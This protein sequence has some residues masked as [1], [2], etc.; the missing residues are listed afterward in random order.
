MDAL[1]ARTLA[2]VAVEDDDA[3]RTLLMEQSNQRAR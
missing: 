2:A 3:K 1:A